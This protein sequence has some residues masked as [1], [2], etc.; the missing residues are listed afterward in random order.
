MK[1]IA[2]Y[3]VHLFTALGAALGLWSIIL[4]YNGSYQE[5]LWILAAAA[6]IDSLD[7]ALARKAQTK[8]HAAQIDGG[9]MD[10]IVDFIT[11]T[12]APLFWL[13]ATMQLPIWVLLACATASIFGFSNTAAKTDDHFFTGFPSYW[14]IV[15]VYLYLLNLP[16]IFASAILLLFAVTVFMP[17]RFVYPTRTL[18]LRGLTLVLGA[19]FVLH[20]LALIY[21]FDQS[22]PLLIYSSFLFPVYYFGLSF[23]L[24]IKLPET[25]D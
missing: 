3:A 15:A 12:V 6:V 17:V 14:N 24:N 13:Y 9:L 5:T 22:P 19:L 21:F 1:K 8:V 11:W 2:A 25:I 4:I 18:H 10:N 23:Y 16:T 7:G 20:F